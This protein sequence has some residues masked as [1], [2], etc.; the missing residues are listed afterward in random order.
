VVAAG[1]L[2]VVV[3]GVEVDVAVAVDEVV[4]GGVVVDVDVG[5]SVDVE[6]GPSPPA[7]APHAETN[8]ATGTSSVSVVLLMSI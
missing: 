4:A 1:G 6:V 8:N 7:A 2:V 5:P 3:E